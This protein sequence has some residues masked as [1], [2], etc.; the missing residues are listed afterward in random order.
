VEIISASEE[1]AN[2]GFEG[3]EVGHHSS[4]FVFESKQ[5]QFCFNLSVWQSTYEPI[6]KTVLA[7][8]V[9]FSSSHLEP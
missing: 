6:R 9:T 2:K 1:R 4:H 5:Q 3:G 7:N 8:K